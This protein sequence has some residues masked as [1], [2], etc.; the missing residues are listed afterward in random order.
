MRDQEFLTLLGSSKTRLINNGRIFFQSDMTTAVRK[1]LPI[2]T[3]LT[4]TILAN[5]LPAVAGSNGALTMAAAEVEASKFIAMV[6]SVSICSMGAAYA[7]AKVSVA[8]LAAASEKPEVLGRSLLFVGLAEGIAIYGL[9]VA[10]LIW[11][12]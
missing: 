3:I 12:Y 7:V 2:L 6:L 8:A 9:L 5:A 4:L 1:T 10:F 11:I